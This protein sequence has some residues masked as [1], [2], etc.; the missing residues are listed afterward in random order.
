MTPLPDY[1]LRPILANP[2]D[3]LLRLAAADWWEEHGEHD[4][5]D[6][7]RLQIAKFHN[8]KNSPRE[9]KLYYRFAGEAFGLLGISDN[10]FWNEYVI[11]TFNFERGWPNVVQLF[12]WQ[13][14]G[15]RCRDC[16]GTRNVIANTPISF[17]DGP[18]TDLEIIGFE[19]PKCHNTGHNP[20]LAKWIGENW[21]V[22]EILFTDIVPYFSVGG[23]YRFFH[24]GNNNLGR[25]SSTVIPIE[26][27]RLLLWNSIERPFLS[28]PNYPTRSHANIALSYAAVRYM[29]GL[30]GLDHAD[31]RA[32]AL[33]A[34]RNEIRE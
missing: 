16:R 22:T 7:V 3:D 24:Y 32:A 31:S 9:Q 27:Y 13:F 21:P 25:P 30:A 1:L 28:E 11:K 23:V 5:A 15:E 17:G 2:A 20:S 6:F 26:L 29:R 10:G 34:P 14:M 19:C 33:T 4:R 18:S 8:R 12:M